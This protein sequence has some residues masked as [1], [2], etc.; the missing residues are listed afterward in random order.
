[1][2]NWYIYSLIFLTVLIL[3]GC[4]AKKKAVATQPQ[5]VESAVPQWHTCLIS[6]ARATI[7]MQGNK[8]SANITMQ[9]VRDSM[10]VISVM[11][12]LGIEMLRLEA[13]PLELIAIDK[14]HGRY[15][16][17]NYNRLNQRLTPPVNWDTLQQ[18]C[19]AELPTGKEKARL[20]YS[21]GKETVTISIDY[22]PVQ[23]D[24]PVRVNHIPLKSYSQI[25]IS[26][27]L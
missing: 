13:T 14:I 1:M 24:V 20:L 19:A 6:N 23:T 12:M 8:F 18:L 17:A 21:L 16:K 26:Q 10:L 22:T 11:P 2:R 4:G 5:E 7:E 9:V 3:A 25:D 15:A 27:W